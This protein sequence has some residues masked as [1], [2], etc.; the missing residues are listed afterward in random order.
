MRTQYAIKA[1]TAIAGCVLLLGCTP[2]DSGGMESMDQQ[3]ATESA[4]EMAPPFGG[5]ANVAYASVLWQRM[6]EA[7]LVGR[8]AIWSKPYEGQEPHGAILTTL[9]TTLAIEGHSGAVW[10]KSNYVGEGV[11]IDAVANDPS[12]FLDSVTAMYRREA[13]YDPDNANWFWAKYNPDGTLQ[14]NPK[15]MRLA[16]RVAKG[17]DAGCI[18]CHR[19]APGG[20]YIFSLD[21]SGS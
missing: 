11:S 17:A 5:P 9:E 1:L 3:A 15:G 8:N 12:R 14:A 19:T 21:L 10:V 16:G 2:R 13:G 4:A 18:A 7:R 6:A 20:D